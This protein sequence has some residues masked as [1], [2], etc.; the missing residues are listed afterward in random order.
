MFHGVIVKPKIRPHADNIL[1]L[2]VNVVT[3]PLLIE[4]LGFVLSSA[5]AVTV[6]EVSRQQ[7]FA[8]G[9]QTLAGKP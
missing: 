4:S 2:C 3:R 1:R 8:R 6:Y 5:V 7:N 9:V